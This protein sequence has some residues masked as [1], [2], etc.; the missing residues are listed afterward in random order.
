M[1]QLGESDPDNIDSDLYD[2][3]SILEKMQET[4]CD[5]LSNGNLTHEDFEIEMFKTRYY[6]DIK[7]KTFVLTDEDNEILKKIREIKEK[8]INDYK[9]GSVT[10]QDF[11]ISYV[12]YIRKEYELLKRG[13]IKNVVDSDAVLFD[14]DTPLKDKLEKLHKNELKKIRQVATKKGIISPRLPNGYKQKDID[15]YYNSNSANQ[16]PEIDQYIKSWSAFK[17]KTEFYMSSFEVSRLI[18][19]TETNKQEFEFKMVQPM[20]DKLGSIFDLEKRSNL[21]SP[22]EQLYSD[23]INNIKT[24]LRLMSRDDLLKCASAGTEKFMS[25]IE[26]LKTNKQK[27]F[28]FTEH[29]LDY[30][31]LQ[32]T[33]IEENSSYYKVNGGEIFKE[34]N[35]TLPNVSFSGNNTFTE[36][37]NSGHYAIKEGVNLEDIGTD[38]SSFVTVLPMDESVYKKLATESG[39]LT[40]VVDMWELRGSL[41][42]T[43]MRDII[44]R[45]LSFKDYITDLKNILLENSKNQKGVIRDSLLNKIRK[46]RYYLIYQEDIEL[47]NTRGHTSVSNLFK[48]RLSI[49]E[50]RKNGLY[51]LISYFTRYYTS[52]ENIIENFETEIFNYSSVNYKENIDKIIFLV[53]N[54]QTK[55]SDLIEGNESIIALL[56]YETPY[57]L[58]END[59]DISGDKQDNINILLQWKPYSENLYNYKTELE[60]SLYDFNK[61]KK[62]H[63]EL[64][65]LLIEQ[66]MSEYSEENIWNNSIEKYKELQIP[67]G[68]IELNFKLRFLLRHRNKLPSRRIYRIAKI[69]ERI[70][71]RDILYNTFR[72]C[73]APDPQEYS[74]A[75]E[76]IIYEFSKSNQDYLYYNR[77]INEEYKKLC[78]FV[79]SI[80]C[81]NLVE[82]EKCENVINSNELNIIITEFIITQGEFSSV[83]ISR[84]NLFLDK[85]NVSGLND[86]IKTLRGEEINSFNRHLLEKGNKT[87]SVNIDYLKAI[88]IIKSAA[89]QIRLEKLKN[90][91]ANTYK[92][93][94]IS[95]EKPKTPIFGSNIKDYIKVGDSYI[96]GGNFPMFHMYDINGDVLKDNYTR[97]DL[98]KLANILRLEL[99]DNSFELW[100]KIMM[101]IKTYNDKETVV[102]MIDYTPIDYNYYEYLKLPSKSIHYTIRPRIGVKEP[103]YAY[104]VSKDEHKTFGVPYEYDENTVPVYDIA[105]KEKVDNGFIIIEGP[106]IFKGQNSNNVLVGENYI[107]LEYN[108][109]R[110]KIVKFREGVADKKIITRKLEE[111]DTCGRFKNESSCNDVNS[112]SL[113]ISGLKY[114]CKWLEMKC[115]GIYMN[116]EILENFD[117]NLVVFKDFGK[118][119]MWKEAKEKSIKF[120]ENLLKIK[121]LTVDEIQTLSRDQKQR[122]L[123]YHNELKIKTYKKLTAIKEETEEN[124]TYLELNPDLMDVLNKKQ[125]TFITKDIIEDG[126]NTFT[127]Y[128]FKI[129]KRKLPLGRITI[130][131][132]YIINDKV[133][134]PKEISEDNKYMCE[135]K[136]TDNIIFLE[137]EE[138]RKTTSEMITVAEPIQCYV[139]NEDYEM[140]NNYRGYYW[141]KSNDVYTTKSENEIIKTTELVK[142]TN[143]PGSF[144]KIIDD[145]RL[146]NGKPLIGKIEIMNAMLYS[147]FSTFSSD[148]NILYNAIKKVNA[149]S[150]SIKFAILNNVDINEL[151]KTVIGTINLE[152]V[153]D[154]IEKNSPKFEILTKDQLQEKLEAA[155]LE[156]DKETLFKYITKAKNAGVESGIL[157][158]A[159]KK[160]KNIPDTPKPQK[161]PIQE[162]KKAPTKNK[163]NIYIQTRRR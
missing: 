14:I 130:G 53:N 38:L 54:H 158:E 108:D 67:E 152:H 4:L 5:M 52:S 19:N 2:E 94:L 96:Y 122:L 161:T 49:Y 28:K 139:S 146:L 50:M 93:P 111:L 103:G 43:N 106:C 127:I 56:N 29:P 30:E 159:L 57:I 74:I 153:L 23:R 136:G 76:N 124:R 66:I 82:S 42:G 16:N 92:P 121:E 116:E 137:A 162:P 117:I 81:G 118:N 26:K 78:S 46:I 142:M 128:D 123:T 70:A 71:A 85:V 163:Q 17:S 73:E 87:G 32:K 104:P 84:L 7:T 13:E 145:T 39:N 63:T 75:T 88:R 9:F 72:K 144:I 83:D 134:I 24:R 35:Y 44:K 59:I 140:L 1:E 22:D 129:T 100:K 143:L 12:F 133:I 107:V 47:Y 150:D 45:Y 55:L 149:L 151:F 79:K 10:E 160:I 90:I 102:K 91:A 77:I 64:S 69:K 114:K 135:V 119:K 34:Y 148:D 62:N 20:S 41:S 126:Y 80:K 113:D 58:P 36:M 25:Y 3:I 112:F 65:N 95:N 115:K 156:E 98:E 99:V 18:Y 8:L 110:G 37:G 31:S 21:L 68:F 101:Y 33:L 86:Y 155:I 11:N 48:D 6:I 61:F 154:E 132:E 51:K 109:S 138:F 40:N 141:Y 27:V 105:L 60:D 15:D 89:H 157:K 131:K 147:G 120:I 97:S 125:P